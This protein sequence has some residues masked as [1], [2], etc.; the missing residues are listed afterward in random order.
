MTFGY[1]GRCDARMTHGVAVLF[2]AASAALMN[3]HCGEPVVKSNSAE[4]TTAV[5]RPTRS[6]YHGSLGA[7][8]GFEKRR[9]E[10]VPHSPPESPWPG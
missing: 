4:N 2:T 3:S 7:A 6:V 9:S 5:S 8:S 1:I 10:G